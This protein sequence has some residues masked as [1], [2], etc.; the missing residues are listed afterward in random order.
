MKYGDFYVV[1][2]PIGNLKDITY[3]AVEVLSS[4]DY[5]ACEDTRV[6][7][8]LL[9]K[10]NISTKVFDYHKFNEKKCSGKVLDLL[11]DGKSVALVSDAGTPGISD[12]G[13][14]LLNELSKE[15]IK[16]NSIP[17]ASAVSTFLA[18][19]S[20]EDEFFTFGGFLP[21]VKSQQEKLFLKFKNINF[22]FY[23]AANRLIA[24]LKT[25]EE[26]L[27]SETIVAIGREL[28]KLYE[29]I[30]IDS[31]KNIIEYYEKNTLKGEIIAM[32]YASDENDFE[33]SDLVEKIKLLKKEGFSDKDISKIIVGLFGVNKNKIYKMSLDIN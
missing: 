21:R 13:G 16:I 6:T 26:V 11:K 7:K 3:R 24:T 14:I 29:E 19:L 32:V 31:V 33:D 9:E 2:T 23:E 1:A 27:G 25:V 20:R 17:G 10:Y 22:I 15:G 4:V 12:P 5:V 18:A 30:K 28:T 8:K